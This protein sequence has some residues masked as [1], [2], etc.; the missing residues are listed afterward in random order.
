MSKID[1]HAQYPVAR[2][3]HQLHSLNSYWVI[4]L[5]GL[6][7]KLFVEFWY[8]KGKEVVEELSVGKEED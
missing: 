1:I 5:D 8:N 6:V 4:L 3:L 2:L 7:C